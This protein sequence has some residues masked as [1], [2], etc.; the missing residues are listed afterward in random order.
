MD[1]TLPNGTTIRGVPDNATKEQIKAKAISGGL[2]QE[3]D[4]GAP[5]NAEAEDQAAPKLIDNTDSGK[6]DLGVFGSFGVGIKRGAEQVGLGLAQ[7]TM[8]FMSNRHKAA[9]DDFASKMQSGEIPA[10]QE[11]IDKL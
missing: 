2:A 3:S 1:V 11:N 10:T 9:I 7:R 4:F 5:T 8:E 6:Q